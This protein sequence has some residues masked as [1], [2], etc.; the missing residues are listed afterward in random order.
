MKMRI[1]ARS[2]HVPLFV[3]LATLCFFCA[4]TSRGEDTSKVPPPATRDG[5]TYGADIQPLF[6][7]SC[8]KCHGEKKQKSKLRLDSLD[9][10]LVG[11]KHGKVIVPGDSARSKLVLAVSHALKDEDEWMPPVRKEQP[12][13]TEE[14]GL[15]R[16]WID[17]G[18][19]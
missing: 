14:I 16:A 11:G 6:E 17:Q 8:F 1:T 9:A 3:S 5:V 15:I 19:K 7:R 4:P 12:L 2:P 10:A 18:A 13:T